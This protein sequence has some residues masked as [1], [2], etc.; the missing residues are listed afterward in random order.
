MI[1]SAQTSMMDKFSES[2]KQNRVNHC[3]AKLYGF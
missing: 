1:I 2:G 3:G